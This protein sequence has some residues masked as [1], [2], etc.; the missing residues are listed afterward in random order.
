M[1]TSQMFQNMLQVSAK[2]LIWGI[3]QVPDARRTIQ[4]PE[5]LGEWSVVRHIFHMVYYEQTLALPGLRQWLGVEG[6]DSEN[7]DEDAAWA[8]ELKNLDWYLSQ[9]K[10]VRAEQITVLLQ[11]DDTLWHT[12]RETVWGSVTLYWVVS[13]TYQ[14]T[15]QHTSDILQIALF[16]D[17][18]LA[19][20]G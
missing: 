13:K 8:S 1:N 14:H 20:N 12:K 18:F 11:F 19:R 6:P 9:F 5:G 17:R 3:E 7:L 16:W 2:S 15:A 10:Q 4:P